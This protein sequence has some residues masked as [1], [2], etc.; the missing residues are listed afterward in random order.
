MNQPSFFYRASALAALLVVLAL[1][2]VTDIERIAQT[3]DP[4]APESTAA[5]RAQASAEPDSSLSP[6]VVTGGL[7][8]D[9]IV[10]APDNVLA[11][12]PPSAREMATR[13]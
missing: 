5:V 7:V 2:R 13:F 3:S 4:V 10:D 12:T 6:F 8:P 9:V 11:Q 1:L